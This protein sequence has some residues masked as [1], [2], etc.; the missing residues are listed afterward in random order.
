MFEQY[1]ECLNYFLSYYPEDQ[2]KIVKTKLQNVNGKT[3][4]GDLPNYLW[5]K[6]THRTNR[7][8]ISIN[9]VVEFN[10]TKDMLNTIQGGVVIEYQ[11]NDF[12]NKDYENHWSKELLGSDQNVSSII[13]IRPDKN[14]SVKKQLVS[15]E[16]LENYLR[17]ENIQKD[18]AILKRKPDINYSGKGN[19]VWTGFV[20]CKVQGGLHDSI[21]WFRDQGI[22]SSQIQLF[23]PAVEYASET[24]CEDLNVVMLYYALHAISLENRD[25]QWKMY[26]K[27]ILE[28]LKDRNYDQGNLF[29]FVNNCYYIDPVTNKLRD[30]LNKPIELIDFVNGGLELGHDHSREEE[31]YTFDQMQN[32]IITPANPFNM[33]WVLHSTN[34][35]QGDRS[36]NEFLEDHFKQLE[37]AR[38]SWLVYCKN[39]NKRF[40]GKK[41]EIG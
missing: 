1:K 2:R 41:Q 9:K 6:R 30:I 22:L 34:L 13:T 40:L 14:N 5:Q 28:Y 16:K 25:Q 7:V 24:V 12:F 37:N 3:V 38:D 36:V 32:T 4:A 23:N 20:S 18:Q 35:A 8:L 29:D 11:N 31:K 19:D 26:K 27:S 15:L 10:L 39:Q 21:D 17:C 33:F